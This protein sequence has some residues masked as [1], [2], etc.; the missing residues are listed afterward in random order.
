MFFTLSACR[1]AKEE[2]TTNP[3]LPPPFNGPGVTREQVVAIAAKY[4][5]QDS[6]AVG[7]K[8]T[9]LK[10]PPPEAYQYLSEWF[11]EEYFANW[12]R[13]LNFLEYEAQRQQKVNSLQTVPQYFAY[14]ESDTSLLRSKIDSEGGL[15]SYS[16]FKKDALAGKYHIYICTDAKSGTYPTT[17]PA[18]NDY[19]GRING[20]LLRNEN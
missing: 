19:P 2:L 10:P 7:Y 3:D 4:G 13:H 15:E 14:I 12:R 17:I 16:A 18:E 20:R 11:F 5:L 1:T 6:I 8:S 9:T